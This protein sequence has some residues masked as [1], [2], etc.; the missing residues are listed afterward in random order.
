MVMQGINEERITCIQTQCVTLLSPTFLAFRGKVYPSD[1]FFI[2]TKL[3]FT[4]LSC[5]KL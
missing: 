3:A 2:R 5:E 1:I 4:T